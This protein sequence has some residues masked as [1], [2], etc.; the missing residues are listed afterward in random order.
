MRPASRLLPVLLTALTAAACTG[1][2]TTTPP[3]SW[4]IS[5][6]ARAYLDSALN[7][8]Q[9]QS[10]HRHAIQWPAFREQ[11]TGLAAGAREPRHTYSTIAYALEQLGDHHSQFLT[12]VQYAAGGVS[13]VPQGQVLEGAVGYLKVPGY[14]GPSPEVHAQQYHDLLRLLDR[15]ATCGWI[16]DVRNNTGGNMWPMLAGLGPLLGTDRPGSFVDA[17]GARTQ[18]TYAAGVAGTEP[19]APVVRVE[20]PHTLSRAN[21]P[22]AIIAN[23]TTV[24]AGE[25]VVVAFRG[26]PGTRSFGAATYGVPTGNQGFAMPDTALV[27]LT[28]VRFADRGG[29]AYDAPLPPDEQHDGYFYPLPDDALAQRALQWVRAQP[30]CAR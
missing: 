15:P 8:M 10:L 23:A 5:P 19:G 3:P 6:E 4:E 12:P 30:G 13:T 24:S 7:I 16:V 14:S 29:T 22:V 21:P 11:I 2:P 18:W 28:V 20:R 9:A 25:A 17:D 27:V 26:R 1:E